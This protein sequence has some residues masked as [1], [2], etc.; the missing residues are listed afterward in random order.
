M[1]TVLFRCAGVRVEVPV[2]GLC[3]RLVFG[4]QSITWRVKNGASETSVGGNSVKQC[5]GYGGD[6]AADSLYSA[7]IAGFNAAFKAG[8]LSSERLV[9]MYLKR[10]EAFDAQGPKIKGKSRAG[11]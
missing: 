10:I 3:V 6:G 2:G 8:T 11:A 5:I 1:F 4:G 7:T 9:Q